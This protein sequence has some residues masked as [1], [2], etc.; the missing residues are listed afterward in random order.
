[1]FSQLTIVGAGRIGTMFAKLS[2][3]S[4]LQVSLLKRGDT[5]IL[6]TGPILVCT[7]NDDL[8]GVLSWIPA[9]RISDL[10][11]VQNGMLQTWLE[12]HQ[13][14]HCTQALLYVAVSSVGDEPID[15]GRSVVTGHHAE[16]LV[17]MMNQLGLR[18]TSISRTD[19]MVE[20]LEKLLWNCVFGLL[21]E[22][23][24]LS[25]GKVVEEHRSVVEVLTG[26]L[27]TIACDELS[28]DQ[29]DIHK[30]ALVDRLCAYSLSIPNYQGKVKE[31]PWRNGW[32]V[33]RQVV[34]NSVHQ[35][36]LEK[37]GL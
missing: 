24:G 21:S 17:W 20:M 10:I 31:W 27:L 30:Q 8:E 5:S 7:R 4:R 22:A 23:F 37:V 28:I 6:P 15:G 2:T 19:F 16:S 14:E 34:K 3:V 18:C 1:M 11:F 12:R 29:S 36:Y 33:E 13:V 32:F 26:E 9:D 25:V 35:Q